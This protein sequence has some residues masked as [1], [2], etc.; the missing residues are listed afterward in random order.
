M[1][2]DK[3]LEL[4]LEELRARGVPYFT[5]GPPAFRLAWR[6]GAQIPPPLFAR[7]RENFLYAAVGY[8]GGMTFTS[9]VAVL[10]LAAPADIVILALLLG[11][12][13]GIVFGAVMAC[14]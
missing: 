3:R 8:G 10:A 14:Y 11:V 7:F 13:S 1:D 5:A 6:L 2:F 12:G 4:A 9:L